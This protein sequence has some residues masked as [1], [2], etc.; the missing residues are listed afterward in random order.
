MSQTKTHQ[1]S[2]KRETLDESATSSTSPPREHAVTP[3]TAIAFGRLSRDNTYSAS[4]AG[5]E[6]FVLYDSWKDKYVAVWWTTPLLC[7]RI[8]TMTSTGREVE[9]VVTAVSTPKG[10]GNDGVDLC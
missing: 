2:W 9:R 10:P 8:A 5:E 1:L 4:E 3:T 6:P 7:G